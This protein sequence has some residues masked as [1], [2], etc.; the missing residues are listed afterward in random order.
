MFP[1]RHLRL[2]LNFLSQRNCSWD[3]VEPSRAQRPTSHLPTPGEKPVHPRPHPFNCNSSSYVTAMLDSGVATEFQWECDSP[4]KIIPSSG[5]L[6]P[7]QS[8]KM[9]ANFSPLVPSSVSAHCSVLSLTV[10]FSFLMSLVICVCWWSLPMEDC[11]CV[12]SES[13]LSFRGELCP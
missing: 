12:Q 7:K 1:C 13:C 9:T 5:S 8:C 4:F 2:M 3:C 6:A 11:L 10:S